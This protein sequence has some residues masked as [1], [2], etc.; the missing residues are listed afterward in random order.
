TTT[1][2][3]SAS[4]RISAP[5]R[6]AISLSPTTT[7]SARFP[8]VSVTHPTSPK[9]SSSGTSSTVSCPLKSET[10]KKLSSLM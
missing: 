4:P 1:T 5:R 3:H 2:S 7:S 9:F 10:L 8:R 6:P